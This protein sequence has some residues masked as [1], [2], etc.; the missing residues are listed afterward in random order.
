MP[1]RRGWPPPHCRDEQLMVEFEHAGPGPNGA[2]DYFAD[3]EGQVPMNKTAI[4]ALGELGGTFWVSREWHIAHCVFYWQKY[5]RRR[6]TGTVLRLIS[7]A[8]AMPSTALT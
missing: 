1:C 8:F 6:E 4:A 7:I 3:G 2:W 5:I